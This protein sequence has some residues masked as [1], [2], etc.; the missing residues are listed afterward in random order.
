M[1]VMKLHPEITNNCEYNYNS[2]LNFISLAMKS[3]ESN[4]YNSVSTIE[5]LFYKM[6]VYQIGSSV[7]VSN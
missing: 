3:K 2:C 4:K 1:K 6:H 5:I 7:N